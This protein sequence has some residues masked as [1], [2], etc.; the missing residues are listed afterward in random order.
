MPVISPLATLQR[1]LPLMSA[2][3]A[4]W[5]AVPKCMPCPWLAAALRVLNLNL[6]HLYGS[7]PPELGAL[8]SLEQLL[9]GGNRLTGGPPPYLAD[10]PALRYVDLDN[11]QLAGGWGLDGWAGWWVGGWVGCMLGRGSVC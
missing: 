7:L 1:C 3:H 10:F 5:H 2:P 6:N 4:S 9:L 8:R 11:N